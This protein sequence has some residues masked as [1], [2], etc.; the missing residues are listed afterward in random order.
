MPNIFADQV[1]H[2]IIHQGHAIVGNHEDI[3]VLLLTKT[4]F[5]N[6]FEELLPEIFFTGDS[7]R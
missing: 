3:T 2:S 7:F 1:P 5:A 6:L 4:N